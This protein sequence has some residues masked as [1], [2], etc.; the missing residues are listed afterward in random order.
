MDM[1][2]PAALQQ[3]QYPGGMAR[4]PSNLSLMINKL[5]DMNVVRVDDPLSTS[6]EVDEVGKRTFVSFTGLSH[7]GDA[8][9]SEVGR[10]MASQGRLPGQDAPTAQEMRSMVD[11]L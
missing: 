10:I 5:Q 3:E 2:A 9:A 4:T 7:E 6:T 11:M 8:D 1:H